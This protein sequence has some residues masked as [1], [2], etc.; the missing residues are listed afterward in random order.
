MTASGGDVAQPRTGYR[1]RGEQVRRAGSILNIGT[2]HGKANP[3]RSYRRRMNSVQA[4]VISVLSR[5]R[6]ESQ[7]PVFT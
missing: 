2:L 4:I 3:P 5:K 1:R 7:V 6:T